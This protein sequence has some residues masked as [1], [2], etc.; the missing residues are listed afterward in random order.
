MRTKKANMLISFILD[1]TG[2]MLENK[3]AVIEGFNEYINSLKAKPESKTAK[4]TLTKFNSGK[5][6][7][8]HEGI[9]VKD[10][11]LL[12]DKTYNPED[13]TPLYDAIGRTIASIDASIGS[14]KNNVLFVIQTDGYENASR[15]YTREKIF[16]LIADRKA[17]GWTFV[18][19]GADIDTYAVGATLGISKGNIATYSG[20][21]TRGAM[22]GL[23]SATA[24]YTAN[25]INSKTGNYETE[26]LL[27]DDKDQSWQINP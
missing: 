2:S 9:P 27:E 22:S 14:G 24:S 19:I 10:V 13:T 12:T 3:S 17:S 21:N 16:D 25:V 20:A 15:E 6:E 1:E 7:I 8:I 11:A 23:A 4:F 26:N 18:F 5:T